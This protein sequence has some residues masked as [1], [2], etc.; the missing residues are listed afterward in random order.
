MSWSLYCGCQYA[1]QSGNKTWSF[2]PNVIIFFLPFALIALKF[3]P[4]SYGIIISSGLA[5][6]MAQ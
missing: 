5:E 2:A 1:E 3:S 6:Q 4:E